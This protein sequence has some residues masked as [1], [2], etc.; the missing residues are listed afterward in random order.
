M[1][2][3]LQRLPSYLDFISLSIYHGKGVG[4]WTGTQLASMLLS[5]VAKLKIQRRD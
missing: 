4:D 5:T 3:L 2:K 1:G